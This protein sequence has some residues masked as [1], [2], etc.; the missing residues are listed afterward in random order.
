MYMRNQQ[1]PI[2]AGI[3]RR[4]EKLKIFLLH[5]LKIPLKKLSLLKDLNE[6]L[7]KYN[8]TLLL[9]E[10]K[11]NTLTLSMYTLRTEWPIFL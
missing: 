11:L 2:T 7:P 5:F 9:I 3:L 6:T 10:L 8:L 1:L 4:K